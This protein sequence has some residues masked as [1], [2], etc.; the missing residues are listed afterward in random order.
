M[1]HLKS[2]NENIMDLQL[3]KT[4][5]KSLLKDNLEF[6]IEYKSSGGSFGL[7]REYIS[8]SFDGEII[9]SIP[10]GDLWDN[11]PSDVQRSRN[12]QEE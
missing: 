2:F 11:L 9:D 8:I 5:L 1:E 6:Y 12:G 7:S 3:L 10:L 4:Q